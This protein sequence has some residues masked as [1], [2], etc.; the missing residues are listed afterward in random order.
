MTTITLKMFAQAKEL[1]QADSITV[2]LPEP[3]NIAELKT[4]IA[5]QYPRLIPLLPSLLFA[6]G[7]SYADE[8]AQI[9]QDS[10][11]ACFP[12]VSGG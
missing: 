10:E 3:G 1:V 11:I 6:I 2:E 9:D 4:A 7:T 12:P 8:T 5:A